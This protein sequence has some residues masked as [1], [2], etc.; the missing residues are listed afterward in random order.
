M[1][2]TQNEV[3]IP[4]LLRVPDRIYNNMRQ[5]F[6]ESSEV[7]IRPHF[8]H[9][10][11]AVLRGTAPSKTSG[12]QNPQTQVNEHMFNPALERRLQYK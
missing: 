9:P 12:D 5:L 3:K 4:T 1:L 2:D 6:K 8:N 11:K 10:S 7:M